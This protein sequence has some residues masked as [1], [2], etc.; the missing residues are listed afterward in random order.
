MNVNVMWRTLIFTV[1]SPTFLVGRLHGAETDAKQAV[2]QLACIRTNDQNT[3]RPSPHNN[4]LN[5]YALDENGQASGPPLQMTDAQATHI[6]PDGRVIRESR[7]GSARTFLSTDRLLRERI[8]AFGVGGTAVDFQASFPAPL[9]LNEASARKSLRG[10]LVQHSLFDP[11]VHRE[12]GWMSLAFSMDVPHRLISLSQKLAVIKVMMEEK[13]ISPKDKYAAN[14]DILFLL[15]LATSA[16]SLIAGSDKDRCFFQLAGD[17]L[18]DGKVTFYR[19]RNFLSI[20]MGY[21]EETTDLAQE[22]GWDVCCYNIAKKNLAVLVKSDF[23]Y[24][25]FPHSPLLWSPDGSKLLFEG[26]YEP[27]GL[28]QRNNEQPGVYVYDVTTRSRIRLTNK[29]AREVAVCWAPDNHRFLVQVYPNRLRPEDANDR[30]FWVVDLGKGT[31][32]L[33]IPL[34]GRDTSPQGF[35]D[36]R[37]TFRWS[38]DGRYLAFSANFTEAGNQYDGFFVMRD[39]QVGQCRL[40]DKARIQPR[41]ERKGQIHRYFHNPVWLE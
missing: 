6:T 17:I 37:D 36:F 39:G 5:I 31:A 30:G 29:H 40:I 9:F 33:L 14:Y 24:Q 18:C 7:M 38:P 22:G 4:R 1:A 3:T 10:Y 28:D 15:D 32:S 35:Y 11:A 41:A 16:S 13:N 34:D 8:A 27:T 2:Y 25:S 20:M 12:P 21:E 23:R 26:C 19:I